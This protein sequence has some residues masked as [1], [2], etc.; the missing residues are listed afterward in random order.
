MRSYIK[1]NWQSILFIGSIL[2]FLCMAIPLM[3]S[4]GVHHDE[5]L[6]GLI[7][8]DFISQFSDKLGYVFDINNKIF[9]QKDVS[10]FLINDIYLPV[11]YCYY[12]G[13]VGIW[14]TSLLLLLFDNV[15]F[16]LRFPYVI[17]AVLTFLCV[18]L[19]VGK[20]FDKTKAALAVLFLST[21]TVYLQSVIVANFKD[22]VHQIAFFYAAVLF[23]V[24]AFYSKKRKLL[25]LFCGSFMLGVGLMAKYMFFGFLAPLFIA[26]LLVKDLRRM[27]FKPNALLV[28][29]IGFILGFLP[30]L[31]HYISE[32][33]QSFFVFF[34]SL[35]IKSGSD[36]K[37]NIVS[38]LVKRIDDFENFAGG[39]ISVFVRDADVFT[40]HNF[41]TF[42]LMLAGI[43]YFS[44][45]RVKPMIVFILFYA[46]LFL[47]T[48]FVP[49]M[50]VASH[51]VMLFPFNEII[52]ACFVV[53]F[54]AQSWYKRIFGK[55]L[56]IC[57]MIFAAFF[58]YDNIKGNFMLKTYVDRNQVQPIW[59]N[60]IY[61]VTDYLLENKI[62]RI[63]SV[64]LVFNPKTVEY[65]TKRKVIAHNYWYDFWYKNNGVFDDLLNT[66]DKYE[67]ALNWFKNAAGNKK[68]IYFLR[69][70]NFLKKEEKPHI[71][72]EDILRE[73]GYKIS[74]I[75]VFADIHDE[76]VLL[77]AVK[78]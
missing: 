28:L 22:E 18:Y 17:F 68:E 4:L 7:G 72:V 45:K 31:I 71:F 24:Y 20:I 43:I 11:K 8:L 64:G 25:F 2:Y 40:L 51:M 67:T 66:Y 39:S 47:L 13:T 38:S 77:K 6:Q 5:C 69:H 56:S 32:N 19:L 57:L 29:L 16:A 1:N 41:R 62:E 58:L 33:F 27:F 34:D 73:Q 26:V 78:E 55:L 14:I 50:S 42:Y 21:N 61:P 3:F 63:F 76:I 53:S 74:K 59:S 54:V 48:L 12:E 60:Q 75:H 52:I 70:D 35:F 49:N 10:Y 46:G 30:I 37:L 44:F 23:F 9:Y 36:E 65:V 15:I